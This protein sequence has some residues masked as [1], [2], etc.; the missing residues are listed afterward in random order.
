MLLKLQGTIIRI[1]KYNRIHVQCVN[2]NTF[3]DM[4]VEDD[5]FE[6]LERVTERVLSMEAAEFVIPIKNNIIKCNLNKHAKFYYM[7]QGCEIRKL[8]GRDVTIHA[9]CQ[10]YIY[11]KEGKKIA[12]FKLLVSSAKY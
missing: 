6:K 2:R 1:D 3:S 4:Q 11:E 8:L 12:G 5:T 10:E 7:N 9:T